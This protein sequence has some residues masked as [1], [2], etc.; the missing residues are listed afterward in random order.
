MVETFFKG[1]KNIHEILVIIKVCCQIVCHYVHNSAR[2]TII[3][4]Y[5][6][7]WVSYTLGMSVRIAQCFD[8][9][10]LVASN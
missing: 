6:L 10:H 9:V 2:S 7:F 5:V 3:L 4:F 1:K 8:N